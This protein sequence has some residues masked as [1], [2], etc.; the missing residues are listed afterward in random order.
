MN[1]KILIPLLAYLL[2]V[3]A[4]SLFAVYQQ[5]RATGTFLNE[6]FLGGRTLGG[7]CWQ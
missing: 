6:Y 7:F 3:A 4:I 1:T 2:I 5:K